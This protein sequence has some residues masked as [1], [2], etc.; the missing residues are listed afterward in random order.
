[1]KNSLIALAIFAFTAGS[2]L[3]TGNNNGPTNATSNATG[4]TANANGVGI[5]TG[6]G[7]GGTANATGVGIGQG[8]QGGQ[9]GIGMGGQGGMGFGTGGNVNASGNSANTNFNSQD[10]RQG[11][12]AVGGQGGHSSASSNSGGNVMLGGTNTATQSVGLGV[13]VQ[14][15][16]IE[17]QARNPVG[18]AYA[19]PLTVS[20]GTCLGS[21]SGGLQTVGVGV[22]FGST[23]MDEGCN[24]RYDSL[25]LNALGLR[26]AAIARL[27]QVEANA[28]AIESTG[29]VCPKGAAV[30]AP[31][32]T[33]DDTA[34]QAKYTDPIIRQRL[35][36]PP[37]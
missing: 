33:N 28:K 6:I 34:A 11:Q 35:G 31:A 5:A 16:T 10:Q 14:G 23:K 3:A 36:L 2:A 18:T 37:L 20:N 15:D 9:G 1:M 30:S 27:C 22:S 7:M 32:A 13:T 21:A 4:G 19:A 17:A 24:A 8:G 26:S 29:G 25:Y 12:I